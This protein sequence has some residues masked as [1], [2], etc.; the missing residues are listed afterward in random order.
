MNVKSV[1]TRDYEEKWRLLARQEQTQFKA[2][3]NSP[4]VPP[5]E[6]AYTMAHS[7]KRVADSQQ[8]DNSKSQIVNQSG[9]LKKQSQFARGQINA[10][11]ALTKV[12]ENRRDW[13][14]PRNKANQSQFPFTSSAGK[15]YNCTVGHIHAAKNI[16]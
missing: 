14:L 6:M 2:N 12:Y 4:P 16:Q 10:K 11:S 15:V 7:V 5:M 13:R 8:I 9:D 3:F 1:I